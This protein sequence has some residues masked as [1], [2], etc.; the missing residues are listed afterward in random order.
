[1]FVKVIFFMSF[2]LLVA[3]LY[4]ARTECIF[5]STILN[6]RRRK[7]STEIKSETLFASVLSITRVLE[8]I[9]YYES[10]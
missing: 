9:K 6:I 3:T 10:A 4:Y 2:S 7:L 8:C 5:E 1:M